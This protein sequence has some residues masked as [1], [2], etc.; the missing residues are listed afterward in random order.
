MKT[1]P[2]QRLLAV[3]ELTLPALQCAA[4]L[5]IRL[6]FG[7]QFFLTGRGKLAHLERTTEF[8]ASIPLPAPA[9]HAVLVGSLELAGG[10]LL[11]AGLGTRAVS[12]ALAGT[13]VVAYLTAHRSEAFVD[14]DAFM[15]AAPFPYLLAMVVLVAFGPGRV[16]IDAWILRTLRR[17]GCA[18][19]ETPAPPLL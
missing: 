12:A 16:A 13:M 1:S 14:L 18:P 3:L 9:F 6:L 19:V 4:S 7:W 17:R 8:F 5:V 2:L 15:A 11:I 10:L